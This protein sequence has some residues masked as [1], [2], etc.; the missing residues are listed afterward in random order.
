MEREMG[1]GWIMQARLCM[2][3]PPGPRPRQRRRGL[4]FSLRWD[5]RMGCRPL[6][7]QMDLSTMESSHN[8]NQG[9]AWAQPEPCHPNA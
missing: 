4:G 9:P 5:I 7:L 2:G 6:T 8:L 3:L 1:T